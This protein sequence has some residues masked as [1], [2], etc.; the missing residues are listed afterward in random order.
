MEKI[1]IE[2]LQE[3][4]ER[5]LSTAVNPDNPMEVKNKLQTL[6]VLL[7]TGSK[8][9]PYSKRLMLQKRR[10]WLRQHAE[11]IKEFSPSVIKEYIS[12]ACIDE[13]ILFVRCERNYSAVTHSI[14]AMRSILSILKAEMNIYNG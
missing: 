4:I 7:S 12:T 3:D 10:D 13:E 1:L 2:K 6:S 5:E 14:E 11:R 8:C 9:I